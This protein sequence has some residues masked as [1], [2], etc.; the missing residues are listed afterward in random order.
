MA[1]DVTL[2]ALPYSAENM[3]LAHLGQIVWAE[4]W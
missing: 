1:A 3:R 4:T 2:V